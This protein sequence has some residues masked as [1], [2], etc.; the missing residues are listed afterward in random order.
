MNEACTNTAAS[1]RARLLNVAKAQSADFK[2]WSLLNH[3]LLQIARLSWRP[4][5]S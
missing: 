5:L 2:S 1:V 4:G 3:P